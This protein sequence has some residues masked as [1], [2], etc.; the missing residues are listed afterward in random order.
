MPRSEL[1]G[2]AIVIFLLTMNPLAL[3]LAIACAVLA[4]LATGVRIRLGTA[5]V[6]HVDR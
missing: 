2:L 1:A 3:E 6:P 4:V 5:P